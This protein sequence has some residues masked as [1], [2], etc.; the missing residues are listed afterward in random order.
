MLNQKIT[1]IIH[2]FGLCTGYVEWIL[3][4]QNE[5]GLS[6]NKQKE[7]ILYAEKTKMS[8]TKIKYVV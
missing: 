2:W 3:E 8:S 7:E 4:H 1:L 5:H 6:T